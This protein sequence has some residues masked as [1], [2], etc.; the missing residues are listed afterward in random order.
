MADAI[1]ARLGKLDTAPG[2]FLT[3]MPKKAFGI[4]GL[5]GVA[6]RVPVKRWAQPE[7]LVGPLLLL[8]TEA[9]SFVNGAMLRVDGGWMSRAY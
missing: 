7:E 8:V 5:A 2:P 3:D 6:G 1:M 4:E 9:G